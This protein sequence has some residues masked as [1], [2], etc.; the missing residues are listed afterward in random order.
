MSQPQN[1]KGKICKLKLTPWITDRLEASTN[2][3]LSYSKNKSKIIITIIIFWREHY[4]CIGKESKGK[5]GNLKY[6]EV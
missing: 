6:S 4:W 2:V 5:K 1:S 3:S